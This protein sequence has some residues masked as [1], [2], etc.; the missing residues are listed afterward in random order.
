M[1]GLTLGSLNIYFALG[2]IN[3]PV[4]LVEVVWPTVKKDRHFGEYIYRFEVLVTG[5][6]RGSKASKEC[7]Y[8][9]RAKIV[10]SNERTRMLGERVRKPKRWRRIG[11]RSVYLLTVSICIMNQ[12]EKRG[13]SRLLSDQFSSWSGIDSALDAQSLSPQ[14]WDSAY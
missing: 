10:S 2:F 6:S 3:R 9:K 14:P 12:I 8:A 11:P 4:G 5:V 13:V 7:D 1:E